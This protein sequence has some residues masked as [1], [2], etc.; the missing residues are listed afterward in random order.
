[1]A[2]LVDVFNSKRK[3]GYFQ[4]ICLLDKDFVGYVRFKEAQCQLFTYP[5]PQM[6]YGYDYYYLHD[7]DWIEER[8]DGSMVV[9]FSIVELKQTFRPMPNAAQI[10]QTWVPAEGICNYLMKQEN[11]TDYRCFSVNQ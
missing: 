7:D 9:T 6:L 4:E 2:E 8:H 11:Y 10:V 1:V 5:F 3:N